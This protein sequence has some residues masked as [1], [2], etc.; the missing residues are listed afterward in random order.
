MQNVILLVLLPVLLVLAARSSTA[1]KI[2]L[3]ECDFVC[4]LGRQTLQKNL[5]V[6]I[7]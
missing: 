5:V 1:A 4:R 3:E 6:N 2:D 7:P